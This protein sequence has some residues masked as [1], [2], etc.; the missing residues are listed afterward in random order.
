MIKLTRAVA[1]LLVF[2]LAAA[3]QSPAQNWDNVKALAVGTLVRIA[4]G[5]RT[6]GGNLQNVSDDSLAF[7]SGKGQEMFTRQEVVRVS[8]KKSD[9]RRRDALIGL[10]IGA[11][12]GALFG[13]AASCETGGHVPCISK[14]S[15]GTLVGIGAFGVGAVGALVGVLLPTGGWREV[16]KQSTFIRTSPDGTPLFSGTPG[17]R[18][19]AAL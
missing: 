6:V 2:A 4:V 8:V 15:R 19:E 13:G 7:N 10:G 18:L 5:S 3:A 12:V 11:G 9:H 16:Y 1:V 17:T 14:P